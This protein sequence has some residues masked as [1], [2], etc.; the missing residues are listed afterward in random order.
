MLSSKSH[1]RYTKR[2]SDYDNLCSTLRL[3]MTIQSEDGQKVGP[4]Q[5]LVAF[6]HL[7]ILKNVFG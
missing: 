2:K 7:N 3:H 1:H 6:N 4:L 5:G